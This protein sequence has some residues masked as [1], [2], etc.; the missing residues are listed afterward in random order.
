[1]ALFP[2]HDFE[3]AASMKNDVQILGLATRLAIAPPTWIFITALSVITISIRA[4]IRGITG[5]EAIIYV[6][7]SVLVVPFVMAL[8]ALLLKVW[9][10][11]TAALVVLA[12]CAWL[13]S[14]I[15]RIAVES[16]LA[17]SWNLSQPWLGWNVYIAQLVVPPIWAAILGYFGA[18]NIAL[19]RAIDEQNRLVT[20]LRMSTEERWNEL[21]V[22]REALARHVADSIKPHISRISQLIENLKANK[23]SVDLGTEMQQVAEQCRDLVRRASRETSELAKRRQELMLADSQR[24][25]VFFIGLWPIQRPM[26]PWLPAT[27]A[28]T[29]ALVITMFPVAL[30]SGL[31]TL[32]LTIAVT[33]LTVILNRF[34]WKLIGMR[35]HQL[36]E[37]VTWVVI[38]VVNLASPT[39]AYFGLTTLL[40]R[41]TNM[42]FF[43]R[44][45]VGA[46]SILVM[47]GSMITMAQIWS[48]DRKQ[49]SNN[50]QAVDNLKNELLELDADT[51]SEYERVC[52]QTSRLLHGPIQ[53]R[54]AAVAMSLAMSGRDE[55]SIPSETLVACRGLIDACLLD[56]DQMMQVGKVSPPIEVSLRELRRRW[57]GL[58]DIRWDFDRAVLETLDKD[59]ALRSKVE[60]FLGDCATN[61]SRHGAAR[62]LEITC[63][64]NESGL[65]ELRAEDDGRGLSHKFVPGSGLGS[66]GEMDVNW[67]IENHLGGGCV[68]TYWPIVN[69]SDQLLINR[70]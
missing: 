25:Q 44:L 15:G 4:D 11:Q 2:I 60:D 42:D 69:Q 6:S 37:A 64:L 16:S 8:V 46:W 56:L 54:L 18:L 3:I 5:S 55:Q 68:V 48:R 41:F 7:A 51:L 31:V 52:E 62:N 61:A 65:I 59:L 53:G 22:E 70:A 17:F 38:A 19:M 35:I 1:M 23:S 57:A 36:S 24:A 63:R 39:L 66:L 47:G 67:S 58:L 43:P 45:N 28:T 13:V 32:M 27:G 26:A 20:R 14:G 12:T 40:S 33:L 30:A 29:I 10:P 49:L 21:T 9:Q 34:F 50:A